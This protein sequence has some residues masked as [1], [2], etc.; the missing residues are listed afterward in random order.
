MIVFDS[1]LRILVAPKHVDFR[2]GINKLSAVSK[3]LL[4]RDPRDKFLFLFRNRRNTDI[5]LIFYHR[6]G[7]FLGHKRLSKGKLSWWP[8][9]VEECQQ[10]DS[11]QIERLLCGIDPRGSFH[12]DWQEIAFERQEAKTESGYERG[13]AGTARPEGQISQPF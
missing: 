3:E 1:N 11:N 4:K 10:L 13:R 12:P 2:C 7:Y 9:T 5:K 8:R 6:N